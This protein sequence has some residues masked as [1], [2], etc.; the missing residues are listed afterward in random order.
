M[1][2][3]NDLMKTKVVSI[4]FPGDD[5]DD[6]DNQWDNVYEMLKVKNVTIDQ[7]IDKLV[8]VK[9]YI[10]NHCTDLIDVTVTVSDY[11]SFPN[12]GGLRYETPQEQQARLQRKKKALERKKKNFEKMQKELA[13]MEAELS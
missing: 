6:E 12:F 10:L 4:D 5:Y 9:S 13:E 11:D 2:S 3:D 8:E 1:S 7:F